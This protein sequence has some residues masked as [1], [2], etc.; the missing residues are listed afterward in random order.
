MEFNSFWDRLREV[1]WNSRTMKKNLTFKREMFESIAHF[2]E[3]VICLISAAESAIAYVNKMSLPPVELPEKFGVELETD[4]M[5]ENHKVPVFGQHVYDKH[6]QCGSK[7]MECFVKV[8]AVV[9]NEDEEWAL[10]GVEK[11]YVHIRCT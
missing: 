3:E 8:G 1:C 7:G 2:K 10:R 9:N 11:L 5:R 6:T 4:W